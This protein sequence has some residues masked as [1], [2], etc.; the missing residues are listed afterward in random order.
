MANRDTSVSGL[1]TEPGIRP[2]PLYRYVGPN[3][4]LRESGERVPNAKPTRIAVCA[5]LAKRTVE[6]GPNDDAHEEGDNTPPSLVMVVKRRRC[7]PLLLEAV[8]TVI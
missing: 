5:Q 1:A 7:Q 3:G 8:Q 4:E 6:D 2:V